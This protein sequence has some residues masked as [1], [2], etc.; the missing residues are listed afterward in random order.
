MPA[1]GDDHGFLLRAEHGGSGLLG[2][3]CCGAGGLAPAPLLDGGG[4]DA[5]ALGQCPY[6]RFTPL[7]GATDCLRRCGGGGQSSAGAARGKPPEV[8]PWRTWPIARP[9]LPVGSVCHHTL[10]LNT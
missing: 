5:M 7:Y 8:L 10:G 9:S 3:Y 4:A 2:S 6:A 1:E